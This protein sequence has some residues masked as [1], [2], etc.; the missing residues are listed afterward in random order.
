[1]KGLSA[2]GPRVS[3]LLVLPHV[4]PLCTQLQAAL[5]PVGA[6]QQQLP[7]QGHQEALVLGAALQQL[8]CNAV[9]ADR[10][11]HVHRCARDAAVPCCCTGSQTLML[12]ASIIWLAY[13][14]AL[15]TCC[16]SGALTLA[17]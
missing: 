7:P 14:P 10:T 15:C 6:Q 1:M 4:V 2:L 12:A 16:Y 8:A 17:M 13:A 11:G 3:S 9:F 5:E